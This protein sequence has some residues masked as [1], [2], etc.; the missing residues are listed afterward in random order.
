MFSIIIGIINSTESFIEEETKIISDTDVIQL[1]VGGQLI[2]TTRSTLTRIHKSTLAIMFNG[3]WENELIRDKH[4]NIFLDFNPILFHHFLEQLRLIENN[5]SIQ[6]HPPLLPSL[7]IP[8]EKML[9][10]LGINQS[11]KLNDI[12]ELNVGG[13]VLITRQ[14]IF[15]QVWNY[16]TDVFVDSDPRVFRQLINQFREKQEIET[17]VFNTTLSRESKKKVSLLPYLNF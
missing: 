5:D 11:K 3:R 6:F 7:V 10:K 12:I 13:E 9:R 16:T 2:T 1:N 4:G 8:F 17:E 14:K 15:N